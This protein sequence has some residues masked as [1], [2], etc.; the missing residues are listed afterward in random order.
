MARRFIQSVSGRKAGPVERAATQG[1]QGASLS[2]DPSITHAES[3]RI[4]EPCETSSEQERMKTWAGHSP[5]TEASTLTHTRA[6]Y[7]NRTISEICPPDQDVDHDGM[8]LPAQLLAFT[9]Y[10]DHLILIV[11]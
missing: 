8:A 3:C 4:V 7:R 10:L 11:P 5:G 2:F 6:L 1:H 9:K